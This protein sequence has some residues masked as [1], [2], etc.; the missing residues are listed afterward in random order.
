MYSK[1]L[2]KGRA[3][4]DGHYTL[5]WPP[6]RQD[7]EGKHMVERGVPTAEQVASYLSDRRNWGRWGPRG[8]AGAMNLMTAAVNH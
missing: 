4:P 2:C 1:A 7:E 6:E 3:R 5:H 8:A